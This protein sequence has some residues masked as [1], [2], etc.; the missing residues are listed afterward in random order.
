[1]R[2]AKIGSLIKRIIVLLCAFIYLIPLYVA[3]VNSVK[4]DAEVIISP[5]A[6]PSTITFDNFVFAFESAD[7]LALYR[8]S[9]VIT[10]CS[11]FLLII[12]SSMAAYVLARR[13][14]KIYTIMYVFSLVGIMVPPVVTLIP[15]IQT[16]Q[17]F[18]LLHTMP[19]L[20]LFYGGTYFSLGIFFYVNFIKTIPVSFDEAAS[21]DGASQFSIFFRIILPLLRPCTVT[22][23]ILLGM[24]I[25]NDFLNPMYI[26]GQGGLTITTGVHRAIGP[27]SARW[28]IVFANVILASAPVILMYLFLQK[29]FMKG[30][31]AGAIKG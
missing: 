13:T 30:M 27:Y 22:V 7:M 14:G 23:V 2:K 15:S 4:T 3:I 9:I 19:G 29:H 24:W 26:L 21:I 18:G 6:L 1:M 12:I 28:N 8:N 17:F 11:V 5:L 25:W 31:T 16:L 20:F 10:V